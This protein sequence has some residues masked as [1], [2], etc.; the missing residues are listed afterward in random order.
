MAVTKI[1]P[2]KGTLNKALDYIQNPAKTDFLYL[3]CHCLYVDMVYLYDIA[4]NGNLA[5]IR[6]HVPGGNELHF[7]KN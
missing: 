1:K 5:K 2:I 3:R 6:R 4:V 7:F